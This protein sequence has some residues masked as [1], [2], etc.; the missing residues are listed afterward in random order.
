[1]VDEAKSISPAAYE[2]CPVPPFTADIAVPAHAPLVIVLLICATP[3]IEERLAAAVHKLPPI[4]TPPATINAPV[5]E[6]VEV[7]V[8]RTV[9]AVPVI[10][11]ESVAPEL[12]T[13]LKIFAVVDPKTK[14]PLVEVK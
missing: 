11:M 1:M 14:S 9:T 13:N 4:P 2:T 5:D 12:Y 3:D 6:L 8:Y 7:V 10:C